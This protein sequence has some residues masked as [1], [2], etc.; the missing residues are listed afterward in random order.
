M[1]GRPVPRHQ[2]PAGAACI[3]TAGGAPPDPSE[4]AEI[5]RFKTYLRRAKEIGAAA[6]NSEV[7]G[8][9][10]TSD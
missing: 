4:L 6:A 10:D 5:E 2:L 8:D 7:Y 1:A 3:L 9:D